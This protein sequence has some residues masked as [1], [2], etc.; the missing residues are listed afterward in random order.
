MCPH[1]IAATLQDLRMVD[2]NTADDVIISLD[3]TAIDSHMAKIN[4]PGITRLSIDEEYLRWTPVISSHLSSSPEKSGSSPEKQTVLRD[5]RLTIDADI[6]VEPEPVKS[7]PPKKNPKNKIPSPR[8]R[9]TSESKGSEAKPLSP[10]RNP[11]QAADDKPVATHHRTTR[12]NEESSY[13]SVGKSATRRE[14]MSNGLPRVLRRS[15]QANDVS[16][17]DG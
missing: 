14:P 17:D 11:S 7:P 10:N 3:L 6:E 12:Q 4:R 16:S 15:N 9:R 5:R 2:R 8:Q 13:K 1:D